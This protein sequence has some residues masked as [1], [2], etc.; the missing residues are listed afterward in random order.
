MRICFFIALVAAIFFSGQPARA[1]TPPCELLLSKQLPPLLVAIRNL[2]FN[3]V[4]AEAE[5]Q[6]SEINKMYCTPWHVDR[7]TAQNSLNSI[8]WLLNQFLTNNPRER[9]EEKRN[10]LRIFDFLL[11][12][13]AR[14]DGYY[15]KPSFT[16]LGQGHW[17][18]DAL[19]L[20]MAFN[21]VEV[22][23][24][25]VAA[26]MN[27]N[28]VYSFVPREPS[29]LPPKVVTPLI[30]GILPGIPLP[31]LGW[32]NGITRW[33]GARPG[34]ST[35][36]LDLALH[37]LDRHQAVILLPGKKFD[38]FPFDLLEVVLYAT[39]SEGSNLEIV[40]RILALNP[41]ITKTHLRFATAR[42]LRLL[43]PHVSS[44]YYEI[45]T[46]HHSH[47]WLNK[48]EGCNSM[49][50]AIIGKHETRAGSGYWE[51][52]NV[53]LSHMPIRTAPPRTFGRAL[54]LAVAYEEWDLV[55][56]MIAA[57]VFVNYRFENGW[58]VT[59]ARSA[60]EQLY[61]LSQKT[62]LRLAKEFK[63]QWLVDLL[64][65]SGAVD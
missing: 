38:D 25:L 52:M 3:G 65:K 20:A 13:G 5:K 15:I 46:P 61:S 6:P 34:N 8:G 31:D 37:L 30:F 47:N 41:T 40:R 11:K 48:P 49:E 16:E 56:E 2:D 1:E 60:R 51:R 29:P 10:F 18:L 63:E 33:E 50:M 22:V 19:A 27:P 62:P 12:E 39:S 4:V 32:H 9:E 28:T 44:F 43:K 45:C 54:V 21:H 42:Q 26:G 17:R 23:D 58:G 35:S 14:L 24:R 55:R 7:K 59:S 57:G 64:L 53:F 36:N